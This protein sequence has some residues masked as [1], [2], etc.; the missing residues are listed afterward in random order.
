MKSKHRVVLNPTGMLR[1]GW[2]F[3][4]VFART[5]V[6]Y[7]QQCGGV[8][9]DHRSVEGYLVP[10]DEFSLSHGGS[11]IDASDFRSIFHRG[12]S[13]IWGRRGSSIP[14][15][16]LE[17]LT[18][19]VEAVPFWRS[20]EGTLGERGRL[21]LDTNRIGEVLEGYVP[22]LTPDGRGVLLWENCD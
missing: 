20:S 10:V 9:C 18:A 15:E 1:D 2:M 17:R 11:R 14:R 21:L 8:A 22:V 13:C 4:V 16:R 7:D 6:E 19:L 5:G 3:V 12:D